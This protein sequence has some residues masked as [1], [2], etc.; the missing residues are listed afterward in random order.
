MG[1]VQ[2]RLTWLSNFSKCW[3]PS[4]THIL[5]FLWNTYI[6]QHKWWGEQK[7]IP[8]MREDGFPFWVFFN[9]STMSPRHLYNRESC[10]TWWAPW[11][12]LFGIYSSVFEEGRRYR[13]LLLLLCGRWR[14]ETRLQL[15][16]CMSFKCV[17]MPS[18]LPETE[19]HLAQFLYFS[20]ALKGHFP[21]L[22]HTG[23]RHNIFF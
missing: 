16:K 11:V 14:W 1:Q 4:I 20:P 10:C 8:S 7:L 22:E 12:L 15:S 5:L 23:F 6:M 13:I 18:V 19:N 17:N 21:K 9:S 3:R 2:Q